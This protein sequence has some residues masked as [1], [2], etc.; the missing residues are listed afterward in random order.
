[1]HLSIL[2]DEKRER[3]LLLKPQQANLS[4]DLGPTNLG[5][6]DRKISVFCHQVTMPGGSGLI[7]ITPFLRQNY[8][9]TSWKIPFITN[10]N[11]EIKI[12]NNIYNFSEMDFSE[13]EDIVV[14][15]EIVFVRICK[16]PR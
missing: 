7:F 14:F 4:Y 1:M 9:T 11:G 2:V 5:T 16:Y 15:N 13:N 8:E 3:R 6:P 10:P 12:P